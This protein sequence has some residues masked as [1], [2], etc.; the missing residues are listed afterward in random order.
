MPHKA[1][2]VFLLFLAIATVCAKIEVTT[3]PATVTVKPGEHVLL[4]CILKVDKQYIDLKQLMVQWFHR[5]KQI[6]EFDNIITI[7]RPGVSLSID[8]LMRGNASLLISSTKAEH[9]GNYRCYVYY[10]SEF[11]MK[12]I[13]LAVQESSPGKE[14]EEAEP[15]LEAYPKDGGEILQWVIQV[16]KAVDHL[17]ETVN[18]MKT[19]VEKCTA[20]REYKAPQY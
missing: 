4:N 13:V 12:Q 19:D 2:S 7:D 20:A 3:G 18:L 5:G 1:Q 14:E 8:E 15:T 6:A 11:R 17:Q 10:Q 16:K 9:S